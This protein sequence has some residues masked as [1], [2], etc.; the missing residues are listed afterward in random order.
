LFR[1]ARP[2]ENGAAGFT[3]IEALAALSVMGAGL[4]A[5]GSLASSNLRAGLYTGQHLA[6]IE[7]ARKFITGMPGRDALPFG[8]LNGALDTYSWLIDSTP[9]SGSPVTGETG[10][11]PQ[12]ISLSVRSPSG[13][14]V[15]IDMIRLRRLPSK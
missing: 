13:A 12:N 8:H 6:E 14:T 4:A 10:W 2:E 5:V 9:V 7:S 3:L 15:Q 11:A 1:S